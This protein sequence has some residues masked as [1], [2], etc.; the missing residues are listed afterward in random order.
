MTIKASITKKKGGGFDKLFESFLMLHRNNVEIGYF[1]EQGVHQ[2]SG[3]TYPELMAF[4][5]FGSI[6]HNVP[7]RPVFHIVAYSDKGNPSKNNAIKI[8]MKE[9]ISVKKKPKNNVTAFLSLIGEIYKEQLSDV[10]GK[11]PPLADN[12]P[13]YA[14]TKPN[15]NQPLI[16]TGD[17]KSHLAYKVSTTGVIK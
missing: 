2:D 5:E 15:G 17:L 4:H 9:F 13:R 8:G 14:Q 7:P 3:K 12:N 6:E 1:N 10:F 16:L 11:A